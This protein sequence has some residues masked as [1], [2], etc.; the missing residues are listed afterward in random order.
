MLS[1]N[2]TFVTSDLLGIALMLNNGDGI[3]P[4]E[5][6]QNRWDALNKFDHPN[7]EYW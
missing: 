6:K 3:S 4:Y 7:P 5:K 2:T 1:E